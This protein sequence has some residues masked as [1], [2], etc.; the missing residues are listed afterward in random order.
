MKKIVFFCI[1]STW[2]L[3][4]FAQKDSLK[5]EKQAISFRP[6]A[7]RTGFD[8]THF[9]SFPFSKKI[10]THFGNAQKFEIT[11]DISFNKNQFFAVV[12][13]G[14]AA[15]SRVNNNRAT[16]YNYINEGFYWRTGL[17]YNLLHKILKEDAI[18]VGFRYGR[19]NFKDSISYNEK[20]EMWG[21]SGKDEF[22]V[23]YA[24]KTP[25][26]NGT[27]DWVELV[28]GL[29]AKIWRNFQ[30]G[31][32]FRYK[33]LIALSEKKLLESND[34]PGFG[35]TDQKSKPAISYHIYYRIPL[36]KAARLPKRTPKKPKTEE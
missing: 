13:V 4:V 33:V 31:F 15:I 8:L 22:E 3:G 12:D 35:T 9:L 11:N 5:T 34:L 30:A 24:G 14:Y 36:Q 6:F 1:F 2:T 10:A 18:L 29:R 26:E 28:A 20:V 19:A 27:A 25:F 21:F 16:G 32:T 17:D 7:W 23:G